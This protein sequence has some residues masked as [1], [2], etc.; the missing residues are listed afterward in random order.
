MFMMAPSPGGPEGILEVLV[1]MGVTK[2]QR[3]VPVTRDSISQRR[4]SVS[5]VVSELLRPPDP[6][7]VGL[8]SCCFRPSVA[9][10]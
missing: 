1:S 2:T 8:S 5:R 9:R 4:G 10:R 7:G 3:P 6:G